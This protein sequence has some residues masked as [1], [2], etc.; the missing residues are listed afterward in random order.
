MF[1]ANFGQ[2]ALSDLMASIQAEGG[3]PMQSDGQSDSV[4]ATVTGKDGSQG[5]ASLS[6]GEF[7]MPADVVS[8]LGNGSTEAGAKQ[9]DGMMNRVRSATSNGSKQPPAMNPSDVMPA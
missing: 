4:P 7:V 2:A 8:G 3:A 6:E 1:L 5:L 9:L